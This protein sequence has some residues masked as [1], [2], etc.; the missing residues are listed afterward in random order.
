MV[1]HIFIFCGLMVLLG[2]LSVFNKIRL[3]RTMFRNPQGSPLL[4]GAGGSSRGWRRNLALRYLIDAII[5][6]VLLVWYL[7]RR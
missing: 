1:R 4:P 3:A 5:L 6:I 7:H 2:V